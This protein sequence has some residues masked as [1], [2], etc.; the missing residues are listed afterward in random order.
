M[1]QMK[2]TVTERKKPTDGL[3]WDTAEERVQV[4]TS[5]TEKPSEQK[6]ENKTKQYPRLWDNYKGY[7]V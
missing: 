7:D 4:A 5:K 2:N 6:T 1:L 3:R